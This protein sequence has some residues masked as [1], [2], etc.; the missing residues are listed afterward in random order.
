[1]LAAV[2]L[3]MSLAT[4]ALLLGS[5]TAAAGTWSV[6]SCATPQGKPAPTDGWSTSAT[7][8]LGPYSGDSNTCAQGGSLQAFSSG[9]ALQTPYAGPRWE[10]T[11]PPGSTISGGTVT[12]MLSSPHGQA[13]IGTPQETYDAADV[14]ANCQYNDVCGSEGT[15]RGVFPITHPGGTHIYATAVCVGPQEGAGTCPANG[16][17]DASL[18]ITQAWITLTATASPTAS[19]F[20]GGLLSMPARGTQRLTFHASEAA[21]PGIYDVRIQ[22]DGQTL[23]EGNPDSAQESCASSGTQE[24]V[25]IF[26][27]QQPC[28]TEESV[29]LPVDTTSLHDGS[30]EL[31][32]TAEDAAHNS[33]VVY[34]T[35]MT[36]AN[37]PTDTVAPSIQA[38]PALTGAST[39][40]AQSGTWD[41]PAGAGS[42][43]YGYEWQRCEADGTACESIPGAQAPSYTPLAR[44]AGHALR[45]L[46]TAADHDGRTSVPSELSAIAGAAPGGEETALIPALRG[47][48]APNGMGASTSAGLQL[49]SPRVLLR[50]YRHRAVTLTGRL[51]A[52]G[53]SPIGAA[54][55]DILEQTGGAAAT[56][57]GHVATSANGT[58]TAQIASGTSR[59][60][61][62]A[63][64]ANSGED[65]YSAQAAVRETVAAQVTLGVTP[66]RVGSMG[67]ITL[68]G[69]VAGPIPPEGV[70][71]EL[72]V[73]YR[74][75]WEPFRTP[76]SNRAGRYSTRYQFQ[77]AIGTFP[78]RAVVLAGQAGFPYGRGQSRSVVES[79]G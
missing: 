68:S 39:L 62:V 79:A 52:A 5:A 27:A 15:L 54:T 16:G 19:G 50:S 46:V 72:L 30:H 10:Y 41:A 61:T 47:T 20:S 58:F 29:S 17:N 76:R 67:A 8:P 75:A 21:G 70:V 6:V 18:A 7:G 49:T 43:A 60:I 55:L 37:A 2:L 64:R 25:L 59:T 26:T 69:R 11:A 23:Y 51:Q 78:F 42:I 9:D 35:E 53:G 32:V 73:R 12:A 13:W 44:D 63:Y 14:I 3:C 45:V 36:S 48:G 33:S 74:G 66:R 77:G 1:M 56:L 34:D 57:I 31:T 65:G 24:G 38:S 4:V 40:D 28:P 71:V 22:A